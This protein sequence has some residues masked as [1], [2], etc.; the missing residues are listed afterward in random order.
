MSKFDRWAGLLGSIGAISTAG[1]RS[2]VPFDVSRDVKR[3]EAYGTDKFCTGTGSEDVGVGTIEPSTARFD[4]LYPERL[5]RSAHD[6]LG[7]L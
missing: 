6:V 7:G 2:V 4:L 5:L 3:S 1:E